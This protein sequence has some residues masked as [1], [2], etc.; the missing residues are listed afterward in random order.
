MMAKSDIVL[1]GQVGL[2]VAAL[3][4]EFVIGSKSVKSVSMEPS[5]VEGSRVFFEKISRRLKL[6]DVIVFHPPTEFYTKC[7]IGASNKMRLLVKRIVAMEVRVISI[8][9]VSLLES[10]L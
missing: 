10:F 8:S 2:I 6:N 1:S 5:I 3:L 4:I 7:S 9:F